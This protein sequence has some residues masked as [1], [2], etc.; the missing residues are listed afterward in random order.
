MFKLLLLQPIPMQLNAPYNLAGSFCNTQFIIVLLPKHGYSMWSFPFRFS[1][2]QTCKCKL[3]KAR[4]EVFAEMLLNIQV[5]E[6]VT[7]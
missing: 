6:D 5:L 3:M 1:Y 4:F 2:R 7:V